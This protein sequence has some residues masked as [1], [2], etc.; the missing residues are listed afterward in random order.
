MEYTESKTDS[1]YFLGSIVS[2]ENDEGHQEIIDGQQRITSLF[3]LLRALYAKLTSM[4]DTPES[5]NFKSQIESALWEQNELT[6]VVDFDKTLIT[7]RVMGD[8]G[9]EIFHNILKT[10]KVTNLQDNYSKN[11]SLF[12]D[13]IE[14]YATNEPELFY[15]LI[16]NILNK[17]ILL[18]ITADS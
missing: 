9:N 4:S 17:A 7:S 10:G 6:A 3:L 12:A 18:P 11:Y 2:Y 15:W 5:S 1:T 8:E 14:K 13:L 16:R